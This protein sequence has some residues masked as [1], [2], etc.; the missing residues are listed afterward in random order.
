MSYAT[1]VNCKETKKIQRKK[2]PS[3]S[4]SASL[5]KY[6]IAEKELDRIWPDRR[7]QKKRQYRFFFDSGKDTVR[8]FSL[9]KRNYLILFLRLK[10]NLCSIDASNQP[11]AQHLPRFEPTPVYYNFGHGSKYFL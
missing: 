1:H 3:E 11:Y 2:M 10:E 9:A 7:N 4:A 8:S 6:I 5:L